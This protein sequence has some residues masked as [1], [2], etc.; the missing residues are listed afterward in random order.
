[1]S[2]NGHSWYDH[3][4]MDEIILRENMLEKAGIL[5]HV[6]AGSVYETLSEFAASAVGSSTQS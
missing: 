5:A 1:M 3:T 4:A 6:G 2:W